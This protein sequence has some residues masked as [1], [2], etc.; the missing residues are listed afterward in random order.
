MIRFALNTIFWYRK[1]N[2]KMSD[3]GSSSPRRYISFCF[4]GS[5]PNVEAGQFLPDMN[6]SQLLNTRS[7]IGHPNK[8]RATYKLFLSKKLGVLE[9]I[10]HS[11]RPLFLKGDKMLI[12]KTAILF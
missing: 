5:D 9:M 2:W 3:F 10:V 6:S 8:D 12:G 7:A 1:F 11:I 4:S